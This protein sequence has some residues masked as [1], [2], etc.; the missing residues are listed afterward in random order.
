MA[1]DLEAALNELAG[2]PSYKQLD[3]LVSVYIT[4]SDEGV[5]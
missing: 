1:G 5:L 2:S 4:S 3:Y